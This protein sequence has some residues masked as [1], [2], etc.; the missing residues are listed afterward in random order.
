VIRCT[1][2]VLAHNEAHNVLRTL[3]ALLAQRLQQIEVVEIIVI[4]S[5]CTDGTAELASNFASAFPIVSVDVEPKRTGKAAAVKKLITMAR[6]DVI[7]LVGA[8]TLPE[9][10][11]IQQLVEPFADAA[12]G[13]TGARAV[14]LNIPTTWLGFTVQMLWH[15]HHRL[16][17]RRPKL[18]E[19]VAFRNVLQDFPEDTS[20]DEPALEALITAKGYRLVY[21]PGAVVYNRGPETVA[22]FLRQRRRIGA[23]Q[24]RIALRYGYF[25]SS[26]SFRYALPLAVD[27]VRSYPRQWRWI[28]GAI[29]FELTARVL[30]AFDAIT[31][32]EPVVWRPIGS[33][34]T[35]ATSSAETLTLMVVRWAPGSVNLAE[36][37]RDLQEQADPHSSVYWWDGHD[38]EILL[39][40]HAEESA[41]E[42]IQ[43]HFR[44]PGEVIP[45]GATQLQPP[46]SWRLVRFAP[47]HAH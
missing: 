25:T 37:L 4:A 10:T 17:L 34:K 15:A 27:A 35:V 28:A 41:H 29:G 31:G 45:A 20:T 12:V 21:A 44:R 24:V 18:G 26:M 8:D 5:G 19:L 23:G 46:V 22:E 2:G 39:R 1:I 40:L 16:A 33:S 13:M 36:I 6:G 47:P 14:P 7:V 30:G 3:N 11:A 38:G 42:W 43:S 9:P 32:R